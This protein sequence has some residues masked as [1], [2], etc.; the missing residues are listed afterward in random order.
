VADGIR[1]GVIAGAF[2]QA[3]IDG[4]AD[5]A[6]AI[7]ERQIALSGGCFQNKTLAEGVIQELRARGF[8]PFWHR[9]VP[10]NDGG[11]A[12]GQAA[13]SVR[14]FHEGRLSCA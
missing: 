1:P 4:I 8:T 14:L 11:L 10:P 6:S 9:L 12:F 13:W 5:V 7:G 2:H 3:L